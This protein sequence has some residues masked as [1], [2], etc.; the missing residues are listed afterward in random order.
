MCISV[1]SEEEARTQ[2]QL[3]NSK[4]T[5]MS[6]QGEGGGAGGSGGGGAGSDGGGNAGQSSTGSGTVAVTN[7]GN[8]SAKNQLPL[9]PR[10]TAEEKEVLYTLFHLHEE[11]IDIKHRKKQR[12]KYSVRETWDK[13]VK[14][15]NSH[16]HVSAMRNIKQ[17]QKF[18]LNSRCEIVFMWLENV[19]RV[20][21]VP[22][23]PPQ[24]N[25]AFNSLS[26]YL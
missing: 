6:A 26:C 15:F 2:T 11:V 4:Q 20:V 1:Y 3:K 8:S 9:T 17:I 25:L 21:Q 19:A 24:Q 23:F 5:Q 12:N 14:D 7:G 10:F 16:P 13:I 22:Q 18:W